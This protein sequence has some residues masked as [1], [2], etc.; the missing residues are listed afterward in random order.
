MKL[1][2]FFDKLLSHFV[3]AIF[4]L[5]RMKRRISTKSFRDEEEDEEEFDLRQFVQVRVRRQEEVR[6]EKGG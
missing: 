2:N 3:G 6:G 1:K 5:M 4:P